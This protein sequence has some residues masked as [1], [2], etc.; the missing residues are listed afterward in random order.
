MQKKKKDGPPTIF[1][2]VTPNDVTNKT[3]HYYTDFFE[4]GQQVIHFNLYQ[5][6]LP[7]DDPVYTLKK[8]M[9]ELD[10]S[11]LLE[12]YS[13][14]GRKGYNPIML[15]AVLTYATLR[16]V[17]SVDRIVDLCTRDIA[18]MWL[19]QGEKPKRDVFYDFMNHKLSE[20][21]LM[22]LHYQFI[23][24]LQKEGL[25]SL[26]ALFIDGTKVEANANRYTF[27]WRGSINYHLANLLDSIQ[28][29]YTQYNS[30]L[31]TNGYDKRYKV[32][33]MDMFIIEGID[34]VRKVIEKNRTR[35]VNKKKK[36]SNNTIIEI[37][38]MS[39]LELLKMQVHLKTIAEG[40]KIYFTYG[41]GKRKPEIQ[42]LYEQ[43][44]VLGER[45]MKYKQSYEIMGDERNSYS[46]TDLEATF[47]RMKDDHMR[48]GQL[49]PAYNIQIAVENY[50]IIHSYISADR[51]DYNSLIPVLKKHKEHL[52]CYPKEVTADSGYCSEKNLLFLEENNIDSYIKLQEHEVMKTRAYQKNI[53]KYRNMVKEGNSYRCANGRLLTYD[54]TEKRNTKGFERIFEVYACKN[55]D[56]CELKSECL[57]QYDEDR[58]QHKN[59]A[60]K[61]NERWDDLKA[62]SNENIQSEKGILNRLIRSIQ[63]EGFFGDMKANDD[64]RQFNHRSAEKAHKEFM[65]Y[66]FGKN[67][68]KYHKFKLGKIKRFTGKSEKIA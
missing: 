14:L 16:G 39:P 46:K 2:Q 51:T 10:F 17:R 26:E 49:K 24:K 40:E 36:L 31:M 21:I 34:K 54:H 35:K 63:T 22:V 18:Y 12:R 56:G 38:N 3:Y 45:L 20:P 6:D 65:L 11:S 42:K 44:D 37:D 5:I 29:L 7:K 66:V 61:V 55:C 67:L 15:F 19:A 33:A 30:F 27:V 41:K 68:D 64:F 52:G 9:A 50:F 32:P 28:E 60:I 4:T 53:G 13:H 23:R 58:H 1:N 8:V 57:Y 25:V 48:N 62:K 43:L 47:M 59:K